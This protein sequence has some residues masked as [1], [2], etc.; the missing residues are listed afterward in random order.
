MA[1]V[2][3]QPSASTDSVSLLL[4]GRT[5]LAVLDIHDLAIARAQGSDIVGVLPLV[6]HP[7]A[8]VLAQ[9][10]ITSPRML[11]GR[12][13]GVTGLPSDDA[14]LRSVVSGAGG[15]PRRVHEVTI[16]FDAVPALLGGRVAAATAFWDVEGVALA[17]AHPGTRQ[18]RVD[19][20]GAPAYPELVV[21][22]TGRTLRT[23]RALVAN[24]VAALEQGYAVTISD[25]GRER[26]RR[27]LPRHGPRQLAAGSPDGRPARSLHDRRAAV[28]HLRPRAAS[29]MVGVGG[30]LRNR[31]GAAADRLDVRDPVRVLIVSDDLLFGSRLHAELTAA[32][33]EP[34][35]ATRAP[36]D[37]DADA[38][39]LDLTADAAARIAALAELPA[40][41]PVV[42]FYSHVERDVREL[43][44]GAEFELV[45]P[46]SR[47]AREGTALVERLRS[48]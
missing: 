29:G 33:H 45:V 28:R 14:V 44:L 2:V 21:C 43:A 36:V 9:P 3:Q 18:F 25:P 19:D 8:A 48:Y 22:V 10:Q 11:E 31:R 5:D 4:A 30:P 34:R 47:M 32:G 39:V 23:R 42:A 41:P 16:G 37:T 24:T 40:R 6:Q 26:G 13:A 1:L 15:D 12:L 20:Y 7:L 17:R 38:L 35:M 27:A 46:R